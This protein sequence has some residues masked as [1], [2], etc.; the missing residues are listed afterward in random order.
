MSAV[1]LGMVAAVAWGTHDFAARFAARAV[2]YRLATLGVT[3]GGMVWLTAWSW[4]AGH[5]VVIDLDHVWLLVATGIG[6]T[7]ATL[8]LFAA[9]AIGPLA[10]VAPIVGAYPLFAVLIALLRGTHPG[11]QEWTAMGVVLLGVVMVA[12][13]GVVP[14][15]RY[16]VV[17][18]ARRTSA[19]KARIIA[20]ACLSSAAF[21]LSIT[22]GQLASPYYGEIQATLLSRLFGFAVIASIV[23]WRREWSS[24]V[25]RWWP[26]VA[27]MGALDAIA[28]GAVLSAGHQPRPELATVASS[29]FGTVAVLFA[30]IF[31]RERISA[32]QWVGVGLVFAGVGVLSSAVG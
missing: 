23:L 32:L 29:G 5:A 18:E 13:H 19:H 10:V 30:W 20:L 15:A 21:A 2:G 12:R 27:I 26:L 22:A 31:L 24:S 8:W 17:P 9:L 14:E 6:F 7:L 28:V 4:F 16:G 3:L 25:G 1:V 11:P